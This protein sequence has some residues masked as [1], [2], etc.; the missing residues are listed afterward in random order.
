MPSGA[1]VEVCHGVG[2]LRPPPPEVIHIWYCKACQQFMAGEVKGPSGETAAAVLL[3]GH[4]VP[5]KLL[6]K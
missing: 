2:D 1:I 5:I 4:D 6:S 3:N